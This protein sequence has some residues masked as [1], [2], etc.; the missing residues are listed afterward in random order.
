MSLLVIG[1]VAFDTIETPFGK[2]EKVVGGAANYI[3]WAASHFVSNINLV[4]I[5]GEDFPSHELELLKRRGVNMDGLQIRKG[6]KSFF[7]HGRYHHDMNARDTL[8]T[9]LNVL[10]DFDPI[11]PESYKNCSYLMLGNLTPSVQMRVIDQISNRPKLVVMD[12]MNYWIENDLSMLKKVISKVDVLTI[13]DDEARQLT[14]EYSLTKAAQAILGHMGPRYL[15]I[16]KGEN[17]ALV[18]YENKV[19]FCP[20]LPLEEVFDPT[21]AGDSFAGGYIGYMAR[22]DNVS[23]ADSKRAVVYGSTMASFCVEKFSTQRLKEVTSMDIHDRLMEF[24]ELMNFE[25]PVTKMW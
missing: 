1:T 10:A 20:A 3:C 14:G 2:V 18:F 5:V 25:V 7:W 12:T 13:N 15:I 21:G 4:S 17:G 24:V 23:F 9:Q 16:K 6:E 8:E 19:F 11:L 22:M